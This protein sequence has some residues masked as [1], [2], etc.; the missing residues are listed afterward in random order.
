[1]INL[2]DLIFFV[3]FVIVSGILAWDLIRPRKPVKLS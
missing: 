1:M 2:Q 3:V